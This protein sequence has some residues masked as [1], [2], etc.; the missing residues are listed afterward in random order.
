VLKVEREPEQADADHEDRR[1]DAAAA[2]RGGTG[3]GH[4]R[5]IDGAQS[6]R[7]RQSPY[8]FIIWTRQHDQASRGLGT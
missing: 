1:E 2:A 8:A 3:V 7:V 5:P 4:R 6:Y